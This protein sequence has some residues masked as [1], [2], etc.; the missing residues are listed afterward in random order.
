[1]VPFINSGT[2]FEKGARSLKDLEYWTNRI[3]QISTSRTVRQQAAV[4]TSIYSDVTHH[5]VG[6][7]QGIQCNLV[8]ALP[9]IAYL[10]N[11]SLVSG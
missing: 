1:M 8:A 4:R 5:Y 9:Y 3:I 2:I 10:V 11:L 7:Y 6:A